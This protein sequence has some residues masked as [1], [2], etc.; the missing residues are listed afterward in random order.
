MTRFLAHWSNIRQRTAR[1][2]DYEKFAKAAHE[3]GALLVIAADILALTLLKPPGEFGADVAVVRP[4]GSA[5]RLALAVRT[6]LTSRHV[7][8]SNV[9]FPAG[10]LAFPTTLKDVRPTDWRYKHASNTSGATKPPVTSALPR[11]C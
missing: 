3:V 10:S 6:R 11:S 5:F 2:I 1:F 7:I 8:N 9:T 4:S